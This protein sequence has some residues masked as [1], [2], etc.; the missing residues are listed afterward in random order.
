M[1]VD[2]KQTVYLTYCMRCVNV[3]AQIIMVR[4]GLDFLI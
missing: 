1:V 2:G 4:R 3:Q